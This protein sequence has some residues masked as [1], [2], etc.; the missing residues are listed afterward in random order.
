MRVKYEQLVD[1]AE[2]AKT[3]DILQNEGISSSLRLIHCIHCN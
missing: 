1:D 2:T 3:K